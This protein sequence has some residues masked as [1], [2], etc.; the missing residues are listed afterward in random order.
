MKDN[1]IIDNIKLI[2]GDCIEIMKQYPDNY[3]DLAV[4]DP[5]YELGKKISSGG[6]WASKYKGFDGNLVINLTKN[7]SKSYLELVKTK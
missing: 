1:L 2:N 4:V 5:D 7:I 3:F 6:T